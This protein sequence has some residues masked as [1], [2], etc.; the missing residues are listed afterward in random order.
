[1]YN[2]KTIVVAGASQKPERYSNKCVLKLKDAGFNVIPVNPAQEEILGLKTAQKLSD[3]ETEVHTVTM[4]VGRKIS[5]NMGED[6]IKLSPQ[7]VIF[8]PGAEN[9]EIED[10]LAKSGI[11]VVNACSLVMLSTGQF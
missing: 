2:E 4:Y 9:P 8:N 1:M 6:L 5:D 7:R 11:E 10:L 3:I